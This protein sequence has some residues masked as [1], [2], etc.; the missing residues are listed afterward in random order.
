MLPQLLEIIQVPKEGVDKVEGQ[1]DQRQN[2]CQGP[3]ALFGQPKGAESHGCD[4]LQVKQTV[5]E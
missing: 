4:K 5:L 1:H 3:A 2:Q